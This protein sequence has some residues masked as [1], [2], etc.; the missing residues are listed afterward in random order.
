MRCRNCWGYCDRVGGIVDLIA[1]W[2]QGSLGN[3]GTGRYDHLRLKMLML[4]LLLRLLLMKLRLLRWNLVHN[5]LRYDAPWL[6][7]R[8]SRQGRSPYRRHRRRACAATTTTAPS[9]IHIGHDRE[10]RLILLLPFT[11]LHT[12][13]RR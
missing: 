13:Y 12:V 8:W 7:N 3:S 1:R 9:G 11:R 4:L 10:V 6:R 5:C 2:L